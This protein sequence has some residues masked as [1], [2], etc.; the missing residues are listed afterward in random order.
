MTRMPCKKP[1]IALQL[2]AYAF[3]A[4]VLLGFTSR[5]PLVPPILVDIALI[6]VVVLAVKAVT[7]PSLH[8]QHESPAPS[9]AALISKIHHRVLH[10]TG[11]GYDRLVPP[12]G[13]ATLAYLSI[14]TESGMAI[15]GIVPWKEGARRQYCFG[16]DRITRTVSGIRCPDDDS[17]YSQPLTRQRLEYL[18]HDLHSFSPRQ[19]VVGA[20]ERG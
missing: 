10:L 12:H 17:W 6:A 2:S 7:S 14:K 11:E 9:M 3:A 19:P 20:R 1:L 16:N 15:V 8:D 5:S 18:L 4:G 13:S